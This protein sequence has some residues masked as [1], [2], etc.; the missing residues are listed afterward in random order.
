[1]AYSELIKDFNRIRSYLRSFYVYGFRHRN[2]YNQKSAR[3]YDNERRR[4]ESWLKDYMTFR[5]DEDGR[6]VFLSVDS[7]S[8]QENPLYQAFRAKSFTDGDITLHFLLM[9]ILPEEEG[10][11]IREI[12]EKIV[13]RLYEFDSLDLPDESTVRIKLKERVEMGLVCIEKA[14]RETRYRRSRDTLKLEKWDAAAAFFSEAAPL[15]VIGA[16]LQDR[17]SVRF[18]FFRF[19]H[20]YIL[21]AL[22]SEVL[23]DLL[24]AVNEHRLII[25]TSHREKEEVLPMLI[26]CSTQTGRQYLLAWSFLREQFYFSRIDRMDKV[27]I[28]GVYADHN[29]IDKRINDIYTHVWGVSLDRV[30]QLEHIEITLEVDPDEQYIIR[31]L[32]R[33][34]RCGTVAQVDDMHWKFSADVYDPYEMVPWLRTFIGRIT[35]LQ[36]TD[37]EMTDRFWKDFALMTEFYGGDEDEALS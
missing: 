28:C 31:R 22:D 3:G 16:Y 4:V 11:T 20:H 29:A 17:L 6:R 26:Y 19:K 10:I 34:K 36:C 23:S 37:A 1:M 14:G 7:R 2:E 35:D 32:E 33:E 15:G 27:Q 18:P 9:D 30:T 21:N 24:D 13:D 8:I 12:M 5:Q 25:I